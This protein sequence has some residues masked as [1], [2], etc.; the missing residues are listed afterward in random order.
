MK[1]FAEAQSKYIQVNQGRIPRIDSLPTRLPEPLPTCLPKRLPTC[2][3]RRLPTCLPK[4][5][6]MCLPKPK[7]GNLTFVLF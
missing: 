5:L 6:P 1:Y 7:E 2:L 3:P 4:R